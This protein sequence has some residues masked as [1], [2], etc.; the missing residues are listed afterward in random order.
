MNVS[1]SSFCTSLI[2]PADD[3]SLIGMAS[4]K[5]SHW[6]KHNADNHSTRM[7]IRNAS[8]EE[9]CFEKNGFAVAT[10]R[11]GQGLRRPVNLTNEMETVMGCK[12][13]ANPTFSVKHM[14]S[15]SDNSL[16]RFTTNMDCFPSSSTVTYE[17]YNKSP[18]WQKVS[19]FDSMFYAGNESDSPHLSY[20]KLANH[21]KK[22]Q[23][24]RESNDKSDASPESVLRSLAMTYENTPSIIRK[25]NSRKACNAA[26]YGKS[27]TPSTMDVSTPEAGCVFGFDN[28]KLNQG[29][30][31]SFLPRNAME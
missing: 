1:T 19:L 14:D 20:S 18:K 13:H 2:K 27:R 25:R 29:F 3:P 8:S 6:L 17:A 28:L 26:N 15:S 5:Q 31:P 22:V 16:D 10:P 11:A 7:I 23:V 21:E 12:D 24:G 30:V 9:F 4:P